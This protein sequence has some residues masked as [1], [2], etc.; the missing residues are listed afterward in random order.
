MLHFRPIYS[1]T[2]R[3]SFAKCFPSLN[4]AP[5]LVN[6]VFLQSFAV[7]FFF[8][9]F[10]FALTAPLEVVTVY[11]EN[12]QRV[13][14]RP[15]KN[16]AFWLWPFSVSVALNYQTPGLMMNLN[17]GKFLENGGCGYVLKPAVMREGIFKQLLP[18]LL[19]LFCFVFAFVLLFLCSKFV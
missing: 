16:S 18:L 10:L 1:T 7:C 5:S 12:W 9:P 17:D 15:R 2:L 3:F 14:P 19:L 8:F 6:L 4:T 13:S 11:F